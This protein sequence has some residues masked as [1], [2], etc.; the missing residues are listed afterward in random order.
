[1]S[2]QL[3][4]RPTGN[5]PRK[6]SRGALIVLGALTVAIAV[7]VGLITMGSHGDG[8]T[9][10]GDAKAA[11]NAPGTPSSSISPSS[12]ASSQALPAASFPAS[13]APSPAPSASSRSAVASA[14]WSSSNCASQLASWRGTGA[15]GQLQVVATDVTLVT[16]AAASLNADLRS[17]TAPAA[18]V[19]A[20]NS[21]AT[22]L[23]SSTQAAAKNLIPGC[24][25]GTQPTEV[26]GLTDL[27]DAVAGFGSVVTGADSGDYGAAQRGMHT[28][29]A[30]VQSGSAEMAAA[31]VG[32]NQ[33]GTK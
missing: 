12:S 21:A 19:T 33:Y 28:A 2:D 1:M 5:G 7:S 25:P 8:T 18:D 27:S 26:K 24:V 10:T 32:L 16:Q 31:I 30:S 15:G 14:P 4:E 23:R 29:V 11:A 6:F 9:L 13:S 20:L 17:G 3:P 22:S